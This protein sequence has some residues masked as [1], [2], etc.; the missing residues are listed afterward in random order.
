M[1]DTD[2]MVREG[3]RVGKRKMERRI[4]NDSKINVLRAIKN[5]APHVRGHALSYHN[6]SF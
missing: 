2:G 1:S 4:L 6:E 5:Q 3:G